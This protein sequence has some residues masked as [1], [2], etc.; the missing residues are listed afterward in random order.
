MAASLGLAAQAAGTTPRIVVFGDSLTAGFGLRK[1][2]GMVQVLAN[3]LAANNAP[4][5][6]V[7]AGLSGDTTYGGRVR[8][9]WSLRNGADAVIVELGGN[10]MLLGWD[11]A[12]AE[13]NFDAILQVA[14]ASDRP[15]L[16]VG[17]HAPGGPAEWRRAWRDMWP[18]LAQR[19]GTLLL[20]DLYAPIAAVPREERAPLLQHDGVHA[21]AEGV[22]LMVDHL[23][24]MAKKL[25]EA[26]G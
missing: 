6:L 21:S 3:W 25:V 13:P 9:N 7:N 26:I 5:Q 8:I 4:A 23:G 10:D 17:I 14:T 24:P 15:V 12:R 18:R 19:H 2:E 16:L 1:S 11:V 20:Q 22:R